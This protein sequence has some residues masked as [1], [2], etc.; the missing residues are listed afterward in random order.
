MAAPSFFD[1]ALVAERVTKQREHAAAQ[2]N[3][4]DDCPR[5]NVP[6]DTSLQEVERL[7]DAHSFPL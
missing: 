7:L 4:A 5:D 1:A 6:G 2:L 3:P